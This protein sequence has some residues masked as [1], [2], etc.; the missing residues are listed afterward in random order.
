ML[1][2]DMLKARERHRTLKI[3]RRRSLKVT[4]FTRKSAT[5]R[6]KHYHGC[7]AVGVSVPDV[8]FAR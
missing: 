4:R 3:P 5:P 8:R 2:A 1:K 7:G 6:C